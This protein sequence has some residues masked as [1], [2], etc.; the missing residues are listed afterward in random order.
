MLV[1][2]G[3]TWI[4]TFAICWYSAIKLS[5]SADTSNFKK[6]Q[7]VSFC[8]HHR[9]HAN[10]RR[11]TQYNI[12]ADSVKLHSSSVLQFSVETPQRKNHLDCQLHGLAQK[13]LRLQVRERDPIR[14]RYEVEDSLAA[15]PEPADDGLPISS[16]TD[17]STE[18]Q[19]GDATVHLKYAP[20]SL[21]VSVNG[22]D[23]LS[24]NSKKLLEFRSSQSREQASKA[25]I[26][27]GDWEETFKTFNDSKPFGPQSIGLDVT[28]HKAKQ[29]YGIP[30]HADSFALQP[31]M[32]KKHVLRDPYRLYN[33]DVFKY[34]VNTNTALYGSVPLMLSHSA[35]LT[36]GVFWNNVAETWVDVNERKG[37]AEIST[38]W[39]SESG[40]IDV[41]LFLGPSPAD[42]FQQ[43]ATLTGY[44]PLPPMFAISYH[45]SRW[46]YNDE[47]DVYNVVNGF[48]ED[49]IPVDVIW[50]DI[51][52]TSEKKYLT[53]D[54]ER[55]PDPERMQDQ[56]WSVHRRMVSIIDP[57]IK[58]E[59]GYHVHDEAS[60]QDF[61]VKSRNGSAYEGYCWPGQ[62]SWIDFLNP[63]ARQ[64]WAG[65]MSLEKFMGSTLSLFGW[66]DMNEPSVFDGPEISMHK[67]AVHDGDWEHRDVHNIYG[68][69][70]HK[71]TMDGMLARSDGKV[72]PF[73]LSRA[74]FA[75]SQRF[76]PVWTGDNTADWSHLKMSIPM[77]LSLGSAGLSFS[78]ADVGGFFADPDVEL[79]LRWYQAGAYQ[80]FFRA[81]AH[82]DSRRR[83]PHVLP[84]RVRQVVRS[85]VMQRYMLLPYWYTT[86]WT[87]SKTGLPVMRPLW[88]EFPR[89]EK[90]FALDDEYLIGKDLLVKPVTESYAESWP[91]YLPGKYQLWYNF[92]D[93]ARFTGGKSH[94]MKV[95]ITTIPVFQRAGS[96]VVTK[97]RLRRSSE[98]MLHDPITL[99]VA[100]DSKL[101]ASGELYVDDGTTYAY[102]N[103]EYLHR[104][105]TFSNNKLTSKSADETG[106][107]KTKSW[108]EK[109]LVIGLKREP[110]SIIM[111]LNKKK[112][113]LNF[114]WLKDQ[115][116][117]VIRKPDVNLSKDFSIAFT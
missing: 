24:L 43:Y 4:V 65:K 78:G 90:V 14:K 103:N 16:Q 117:A 114:S 22:V 3:V 94:I 72:R 98:A 17:S 33:L 37:D 87:A 102:Q 44:S 31:T 8:R 67:D 84:E 115:R 52:H 7:D 109:V 11:S 85:A 86:F 111:S 26:K 47:G 12:V 29:V 27:G 39:F 46:N 113:D 95:G 30:E 91:V 97:D 56:L 63:A 101:R 70:Q 96:V 73:V 1:R 116:T 104:R 23:V 81:H 54:R 79:L 68:F 25:A 93:Y 83:E 55:F 19:F 100:L 110:N 69:Y 77:L 99:R 75:G 40:I 76:G 108:V 20:I 107:Y 57:H 82:L 21:R 36:A 15:P 6:C 13:T 112:I 59:D 58:R 89:D 80:P 48:D 5:S 9:R 88:L 38:H 28:F 60:Q 105:F 51:E 32:S 18:L 92:F 64:W 50:L 10:T 41:F 62:S 34:E 49:E 106:S 45:Q 35:Q 53:W 71:A 74:F 61:Y 66:N 42:I 2:G